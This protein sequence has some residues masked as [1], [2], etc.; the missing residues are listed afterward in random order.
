MHETFK[1]GYVLIESSFKNIC[2]D[3]VPRI[4][5]YSVDIVLGI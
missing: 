2:G 3:V 1:S 5:F 4:Y